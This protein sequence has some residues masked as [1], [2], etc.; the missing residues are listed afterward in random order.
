[1]I[2]DGTGNCDVL[3]TPSRWFGVTYHDDLAKVQA[4]IR[5]M[6][7]KGLYPEKLWQ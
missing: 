5:E 6:K 1:M 4:A 2:K 7:Q 3:A